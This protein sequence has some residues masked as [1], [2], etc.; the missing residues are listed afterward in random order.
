MPHYSATALP[1]LV[2]C[3][4]SR[5]MPA[6]TPTVG[7]DQSDDVR[8]GLTVHWLASEYL[9]GR[10]DDLD[11]WIDRKSP[12]AVYI[13]DVMVD[14]VRWFV[15]GVTKDAANDKRLIEHDMQAW[16]ADRSITIGCRPDVLTDDQAQY[17]RRVRIHDLKY[18]FRLVEPENNWT[19]LAHAFSYIA[20]KTV[21][22]DTTFEFHVWQPRPFS[23][24]GPHRM[25]FVSAVHL[26]ALREYLFN[27]LATT[28]D[29]LQTGFYCYRCP[30]RSQCPAIRKASMSLLDVVER[31]IPDEMTLDDM[32]LMMDAL[33]VADH[34]LKQY[35]E[36]IA[37]RI[38]D[39]LSR[40]G[41]VR[42]YVL[43]P[44]DGNLDWIEGIDAT[45]LSLL[46]DKPVTKPAP[47]LTPTQLKKAIPE[48]VLK[49]L[50]YRKRGGLSLKRMDTDQLAQEMFGSV[51]ASTELSR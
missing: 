43:R 6:Y 45:A 25:W 3:G 9:L 31:A 46:T 35:K 26:F 20:D 38:T 39:T 12:H 22:P 23:P 27:T 5:S 40:G 32:S 16:N 4:G 36:A 48:P 11:Q 33:T 19:L 34:T 21:E 29:V 42:N 8:D 17:G 37:E 51:A 41:V 24:N 13:T 14:H 10:I 30:A 49:A 50:T 2:Q 18:G 28:S 47:L 1:R 7:M 15:Q 44:Y